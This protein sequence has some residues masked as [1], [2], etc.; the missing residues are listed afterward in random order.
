MDRPSVDNGRVRSGGSVAVAVI[1]SDKQPVRMQFSIPVGRPK[2]A[3][4]LFLQQKINRK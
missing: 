4:I 2:Y 3:K 1:V